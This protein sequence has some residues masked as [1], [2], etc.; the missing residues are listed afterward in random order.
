MDNINWLSMILATITP[1]SIGIIYYNKAIFGKAWSDSNNLID[2]YAKKSNTPILVIISII[3]SFLLAFFLLN[4]N[5]GGINQEGQFDTFSHGAWHGAFIAITVASPI[6]LLN[7]LFGTKSWKTVLINIL[8]WIITLALMGGIL[9]ALN[10]WENVV[11][12]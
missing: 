9:D 1:V 3:F 6:V 12:S 10:H 2:N 7:S 11:I 8:Y 5:N 4:F